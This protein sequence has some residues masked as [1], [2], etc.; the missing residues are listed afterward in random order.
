LDTSLWYPQ[1]LLAGI[2]VSGYVIKLFI[3][4]HDVFSWT[5]ILLFT[6]TLGS[7]SLSLCYLLSSLRTHAV[8]V[9]CHGTLTAVLPA[10]TA[11]EHWSA[12]RLALTCSPDAETGGGVTTARGEGEPCDEVVAWAGVKADDDDGMDVTFGEDKEPK[13]LIVGHVGCGSDFG[14]SRRCNG[15]R[16]NCFF[17]FSLLNRNWLRLGCSRCS[18]KSHI[19]R[20]CT[21][22]KLD[23]DKIS[24]SLLIYSINAEDHIA[25]SYICLACLVPVF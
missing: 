17:R 2:T 10:H 24:H 13:G 20:A 3:V 9:D 5:A 12:L 25:Y 18:L 23:L 1:S 8:T 7:S 22:L 14:H 11:G 21:A 16:F 6:V 4:L 19:Q 15:H